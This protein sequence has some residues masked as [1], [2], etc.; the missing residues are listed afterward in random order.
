VDERASERGSREACAEHEETRR[1]E[2]RELKRLV[3]FFIFLLL[4]L[5]TPRRPVCPTTTAGAKDA[6]DLKRYE[7]EHGVLGVNLG[8]GLSAGSGLTLHQELIMTMPGTGKPRPREK[9]FC[10]RHD[11]N[12]GYDCC[13]LVLARSCK[14]AECTFIDAEDARKARG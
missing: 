2:T 9:R 13:S 5:A 12:Q 6:Q 8:S 10:L 1:N 11:Q 7:K 3:F 14:L 4:Y